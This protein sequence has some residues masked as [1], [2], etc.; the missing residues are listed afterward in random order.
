MPFSLFVFGVLFV[1]VGSFGYRCL[2]HCRKNLAGRQAAANIRG[3]EEGANHTVLIDEDRR[4]RRHVLTVFPRA[5]VQYR[6]LSSNWEADDA[7][8]EAW[9][10]L[11]RSDVN[12]TE[13]LGG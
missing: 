2:V 7:V 3:S 1:L 10:R 6:I 11:T 8:Q 12:S 9:F 13:N 5:R 4:R